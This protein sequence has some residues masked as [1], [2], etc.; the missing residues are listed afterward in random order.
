MSYIH[1]NHKKIR[2][3]T[4]SRYPVNLTTS[5]E[6]VLVNKKVLI[7]QEYLIAFPEL[8]A[9]MRKHK[10]GLHFGTE[11]AM[12]QFSIIRFHKGVH[13]EDDFNS[14]IG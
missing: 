2:T 13:W 7:F 8:Q 14:L 6:D 10:I 5:F 3:F 11:N 1:S 4:R 12:P 9:I